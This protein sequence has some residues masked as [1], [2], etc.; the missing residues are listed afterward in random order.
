MWH[1]R[2]LPL[3]IGIVSGLESDEQSSLDYESESIFEVD[4]TESANAEEVTAE[5]DASQSFDNLD[6]TVNATKSKLKKMF[7]G[8]AMQQQRQKEEEQIAEMHRQREALEAQLASTNDGKFGNQRI[9]MGGGRTGG[10]SSGGRMIS[11]RRAGVGRLGFGA[12]EP[13]TDSETPK[14]FTRE[15]FDMSERP[16]PT[17]TPLP[18]QTN[19]ADPPKTNLLKKPSG[20]QDRSA[21]STDKGAGITDNGII[22]MLANNLG[23]TVRSPKSQGPQR[24]FQCKNAS[25]AAECLNSG[26]VNTCN[27]GEACQTEVRWENGKV[28]LESTCKQKNAC[29]VMIKQNENCNRLKGQ[30]GVNRTCWRCCNGDLCNLANIN[31]DRI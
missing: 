11:G 31:P 16:T 3:A 9:R 12:P 24:C 5:K 15:I 10:P 27:R 23:L 29:M 7:Y 13:D 14:S 4:F 18:K 28:K 6:D 21:S 20:L 22:Q 8:N 26:K 2:W 25:D 17:T 30:K 19:H 1:I